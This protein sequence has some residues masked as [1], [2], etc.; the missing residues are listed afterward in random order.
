MTDRFN[1]LH[2]PGIVVRDIDEAQAYSE[3]TGIGPSEIYPPLTEYAEL[4]VPGRAGVY[5]MNYRIC[6]LPNVRSQLRQ[7]SHDPARSGFIWIPRPKAC[8]MSVPKGLTLTRSRLRCVATDERPW[9]AAGAQ[10]VADSPI[11][12]A[13]KGAGVVLLTHAT[14]QPGT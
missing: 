9:H 1:K 11:A 5:A 14:G 10:T 8:F 6:K 7:P 12:I 3:S 4:D 13:P 2:H